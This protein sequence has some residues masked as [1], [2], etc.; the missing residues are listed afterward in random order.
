VIESGLKPDDRVVISGL[1]RAI[2]GGKVAAKPA[3]MPQS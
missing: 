1:S 3:P 2:P